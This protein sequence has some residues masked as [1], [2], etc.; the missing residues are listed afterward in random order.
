M[1]SSVD[2][3][4]TVLSQLQLMLVGKSQVGR[5]RTSLIL[6]EQ[7]VITLSACVATFSDLD[8]FVESLGTDANMGLL[9]RLRW[10]T[11]TSTIQEHMQ[12]L[13][14][15]KSTLT[16]M[17]TILT[18][19]S[20]GTAEDAVDKLSTTIQHVLESN[21]L[22]AQRLASIE[23][24]KRSAIRTD[25]GEFSA[26]SSA[27]RTASWSMLSGLSLAD[28]ISII[29]V[30]ALLVYEQDLSNSNLYSFGDFTGTGTGVGNVNKKNSEKQRS[31]DKVP[32]PARKALKSWWTRRTTPIQVNTGSVDIPKRIFGI[33]LH[34]SITY[35]NVAISLTDAEGKLYVYGYLP[36]VVAQIGVYIK[37]N[38]TTCEDI[39]ARNGSAVRVHELEMVFDT[40]GERGTYGNG[41]KFWKGTQYSAYDA[42]TCLLRYLKSLPEPVIPCGF[43]DKFTSILGPTVYENDIGYDRDAFSID[44]AIL[45]L[46][47]CI[48]EIPPLNRQLLLYLLNL[49]AVFASKSDE[50][51]MTPARIVATFQ[52][53]LLAREARVGMSVLDHARASD[54]LICMIENQDHFLIGMRGTAAHDTAN[55]TADKV[56][57]TS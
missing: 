16:L 55:T 23:V 33:P 19:E 32:S 46:Q 50:N 4:R 5:N 40:P 12:K 21:L 47:Q 13:E 56:T 10:A 18:C 51:K 24:Y 30:Q 2:G 27:G 1:K 45:T 53:S 11:K 35:A 57:A 3:I 54:T 52:P 42:A 15:H 34:Q 49:A 7:I 26:I 17:M 41:H 6:V 22:I 39:F 29:A 25:D 20:M 48:T 36:V 8:V 38:G 43:Y 37:E 28:N 44:T 31:S 14:V 9:D